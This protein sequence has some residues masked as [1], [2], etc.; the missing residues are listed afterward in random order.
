MGAS[1]E[2]VPQI[3][4]YLQSHRISEPRSE[5]TFDGIAESWYDSTEDMWSMRRGPAYDL[6][7][8]DE[9][10]FIDHAGTENLATI[11]HVILEGERKPGMIKGVSLIKRKPGLT[12]AE[13]R[14]YWLEVHGP[15]ALKL[16]G[17]RRYIQCHTVDDAYMIAEPRW[18][19]AAH[20]YFD[21]S[22]SAA[23]AFESE[24]FTRN[25]GPDGQKFIAKVSRL[26]V[27]EHP[28]LPKENR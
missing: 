14:R 2:P 24:E 4:R 13:F 19:G 21:D 6:M 15:M 10:N 23:R 27:Q 12:L 5:S 20:L 28:V 22:A 18:D 11:D 3:K 17:L 1:P 9:L 26:W 8:K 7:L 25:T 16:P